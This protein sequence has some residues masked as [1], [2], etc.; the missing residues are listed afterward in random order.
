MA[1]VVDA[2]V[3]EVA[4]AASAGPAAGFP[5]VD[6]RLVQLVV[7]NAAAGPEERYDGPGDV[8][9]TSA[10]LVE[11]ISMVESMQ[12]TLAAL[13]ATLTRR[14]A[15]QHVAARLEKGETDPEKL[16]RSVTAQVGL[17]CRVSPTAARA[18]VRTARDLHDGLAHVRGLFAA[19][20]LASPKVDTVVRACRDLDERERGEVD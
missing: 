10:M 20:E 11:Q 9:T 18:R 4:D 5:W 7:E 14:F 16:E 19:G 12:H 1:A 3:R 13:Q 15:R 17:A 2:P 8:E 6:L